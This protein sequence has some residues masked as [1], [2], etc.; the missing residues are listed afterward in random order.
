MMPIC[1]DGLENSVS[2]WRMSPGLVHE[3]RVI[4]RTPG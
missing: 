4:A 2:E 3:I 1:P